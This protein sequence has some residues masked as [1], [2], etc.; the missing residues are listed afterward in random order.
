V[1]RYKRLDYTSSD[2]DSFRAELVALVQ[3]I[4]PDWTDFGPGNPGTAIIEVVAWVADQIAYY[5]GRQANEAYLVTAVER[6]NVIKHLRGIGYKLATASPASADLTMALD[7]ALTEDFTVPRLSIVTTDDGLTSGETMEDAF[8]PAGSTGPIAGVAWLEGAT[9]QESLGTSDGTANQRFVLGRTPFLEMEAGATGCEVVTFDGVQWTRVEDFL[10]SASTDLH[11]ILEVDEL[12]Q[13]TII[14]GDGTSGSIPV[15]GAEGSCT[16]RIGGGSDHNV[17]AN[18]LTKLPR[19]LIAASGRVVP[20]SVTNPV[21]ASGGFP[22]ETVAHAKIYGPASLKTQN[23]CIAKEDYE[24]NA[25]RVAGVARALAL[26][27]NEDPTIEENT[28]NMFIVPDGGGTAA[29]PL[30]AAVTTRLTTTNPRGITTRLN[31]FT[32]PYYYLSFATTVYCSKVSDLTAQA[33][34]LT[35]AATATRDALAALFSEANIDVTSGDFTMAFGKRISLSL[36]TRLIQDID[37]VEHLNLFTSPTVD[38]PMPFRRQFPALA[39]MAVVPASSGTL[40]ARID[41]AAVNSPSVPTL[42]AMSIL[43]IPEDAS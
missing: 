16:Y 43:F 8:I 9:F 10:S 31:V 40:Q 28:V 17:E 32:A 19:Q 24:I 13:C 27:S 25:E 18:T 3:V 14:T 33:L 35:A 15:N 1:A 4:F 29:S 41:F 23:R 20:L 11:Y 6:K 5:L 2:Y 38:V 26:T 39:A 21:R 34:V 22:R 12:D 30:L 36:I 37:N 42:P 7:V